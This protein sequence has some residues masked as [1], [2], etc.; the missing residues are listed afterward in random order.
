MSR[1]NK[2]HHASIF[3]MVLKPQHR[4]LERSVMGSIYVKNGTPIG[5]TSLCNTCTNAHIVEGYRE[6]EA[7]VLCTYASYD[8]ALFILQGQ[9]VLQPLRQGTAHLGTDGKARLARNSEEY[10]QDRRLPYDAKS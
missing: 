5:A 3:A 6:S 7:I 8:R 4:W 2:A 10:L 9:V 1:S